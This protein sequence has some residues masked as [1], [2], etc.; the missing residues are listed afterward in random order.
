M[1]NLF[2][3][4]SLAAMLALPAAAGTIDP[5]WIEKDPTPPPATGVDW[6]GVA[7]VGMLGYGQ[8]DMSRVVT[9][10]TEGELLGYERECQS[11]NHE[12]YK[13]AG[14]CQVTMEDWLNSPE[15][16]A[17]RNGEPIGGHPSGVN[18]QLRAVTDFRYHADYAPDFNSRYPGVWVSEQTG[19]LTYFSE[20]DDRP[21]TEWNKHAT[22]A[23]IREVWSEDIITESV[24]E[25]TTREGRVGLAV[26]YRYDMG[27]TVVGAGVSAFKGLDSDMSTV[28]V[29]GQFG[30][31][32]GQNA[33]LFGFG[34]W[35]QMSID[36]EFAS[37]EFD[38][39]IGGVGVDYRF[40]DGMF[41]RVQV[42]TAT[43]D[44]NGEDTPST[45]IDVGLG[46]TF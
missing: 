16:L 26:E 1:K 7:I 38:G 34:G 8:T 40:A 30:V 42:S 5:P 23:L 11:E 3:T 33:L 27:E 28:N 31:E 15:L 39:V 36:N 44:V 12:V 14:K 24:D 46:F 25:Q 41:G 21:T 20:N 18:S 37:G 43:Y 6:G 4:T 9:E 10:T 22:N 35:S 45:N 19:N 17:L 13:W 32:A 2:L 29:T